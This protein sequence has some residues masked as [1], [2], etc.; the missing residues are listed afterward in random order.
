[1]AITSPRRLAGRPLP[2][3]GGRGRTVTA[4]NHVAVASGTLHT[5][6]VLASSGVAVVHLGVAPAGVLMCVLVA[7]IPFGIASFRISSSALW[8]FGRTAVRR[9]DAGAASGIGNILW[10]VSPKCGSRS[11]TRSP[12]SPTA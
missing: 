6:L 7:T 11:C 8:P 1:M 4:G 2:E 5:V 10:F 9:A 12:A 3:A